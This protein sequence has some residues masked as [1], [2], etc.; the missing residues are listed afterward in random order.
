M[1][2]SLW[3][4]SPSAQFSKL[5]KMMM[6]GGSLSEREAIKAVADE[7][8]S[9]ETTS[10]KLTGDSSLV[11][12]GGRFLA[13]LNRSTT[14]K[15]TNKQKKLLIET[16]VWLR[17]KNMFDGKRRAAAAEGKRNWKRQACRDIATS[18]KGMKDAPAWRTIENRA[19]RDKW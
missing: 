4:A 17:A 10:G 18:L 9:V 15:N 6:R 12:P 11:D 3:D 16:A 14:V 19:T 1:R 8:I 5:V 13:S 7:I 2:K